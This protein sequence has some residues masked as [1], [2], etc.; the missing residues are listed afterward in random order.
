MPINNTILIVDDEAVIRTTLSNDLKAEGYEVTAVE[1]G[2]D[3]V[4]ILKEKHFDAV[5]TDMMMEGMNGIQV[6]QQAKEINPDV[7]VIILTGFGE[8]SSAIEA[9]RS[10]AED[11]LQ[12]PCDIEELL[13]RVSNVLEKSD[14]KKKI[15]LYEKILPVCSVCKKIRDDS[16]K[17]PGSGEWMDVDIYLARKTNIGVS[18]SMCDDCI[19]T[20]YPELND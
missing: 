15:K 3:A 13:F 5:I 7:A 1:N 16:G 17:E 10:G 20:F 19:K 11:Y 14:L 2:E 12:K 9:L 8:L 4:D 18:H 6:L